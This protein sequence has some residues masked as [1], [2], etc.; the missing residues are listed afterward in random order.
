MSTHAPLT[1]CIRY[2]LESFNEGRMPLSTNRLKVPPWQRSDTAWDEKPYMRSKLIETVLMDL[3]IPAIWI[4]GSMEAGEVVDGL[5]RLTT[6]N[7]FLNG[8]L[9]LK[10]LEAR[11]EFNG[12]TFKDLSEEVQLK[13]LSYSLGYYCLQ[14]DGEYG[15]TVGELMFARLNE[16]MG[17]NRVEIMDG[18][19]LGAGRNQIHALADVLGSH[20]ASKRWTSATK[21]KQNIKYTLAALVGLHSRMTLVDNQ[22]NITFWEHSLREGG[23]NPDAHF[24]KLAYTCLNAL[25]S[26]EL[27]VTATVFRN[28]CNCLYAVLGIGLLDK[29]DTVSPKFNYPCTQLRFAAVAFMGKPVGWW[30]TNKTAIRGIFQRNTCRS[31]R[32]SFKMAY[33]KMCEELMQLD[34]PQAHVVPQTCLP[35][36]VTDTPAALV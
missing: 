16:G 22:P 20:V 27:A 1:S 11:P 10:L 32:Q 8:G 35:P 6:L 12:K 21:R 17:G 3:P 30:E 7:M 5:Q 14:R 36:A 19:Q 13:F 9:K 24:R 28:A 23:N 18:V 15:N 26:A 2:V 34:H 29:L 4:I 25:S 31:D 33:L